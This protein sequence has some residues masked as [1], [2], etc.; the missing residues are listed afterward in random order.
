MKTFLMGKMFDDM[1]TKYAFERSSIERQW[2]S[3]IDQILHSFVA[4]PIDV[5]PM[6]VVASPWTATKVEE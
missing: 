3:N 5:Y 4:K 6:R 1:L 2:A